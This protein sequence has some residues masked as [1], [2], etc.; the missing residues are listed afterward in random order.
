MPFGRRRA[1]WI[2]AVCVSL[3]AVSAPVAGCSKDGSDTKQ[4]ASSPSSGGTMKVS[5]RGSC[6]MRDGG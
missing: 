4:A 6:V 2:G 1:R 5:M 3:A